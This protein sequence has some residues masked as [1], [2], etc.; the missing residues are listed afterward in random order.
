MKDLLTLAWN[1]VNEAETRADIIAVTS[2]IRSN[3]KDNDLFDELMMALAYKSR[4]LYR[5]S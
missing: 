4:E 1:K 2:W 5:V 3:I